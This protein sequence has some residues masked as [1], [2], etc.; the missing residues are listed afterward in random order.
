L[1]RALWSILTLPSEMSRDTLLNPELTTPP[2]PTISNIQWI[3]GTQYVTP[4]DMDL[5]SKLY[6]NTFQALLILS[7]LVALIDLPPS[8]CSPKLAPKRKSTVVQ[9]ELLLP[10][11]RP[12]HTHRIPRRWLLQTKVGAHG[13]LG[14]LTNALRSSML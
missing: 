7:Q 5:L 1:E 14:N 3:S 2:R 4:A 12:P 8:A 6:T 13:L 10:L 11:P 9:T